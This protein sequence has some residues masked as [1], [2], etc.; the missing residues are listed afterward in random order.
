MT[1]NK[2]EAKLLPKQRDHIDYFYENDINMHPFH[3]ML[4]DT[5]EDF[6]NFKRVSFTLNPNISSMFYEEL[7]IIATSIDPV[8]NVPSFKRYVFFS[9]GCT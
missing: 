6:N 7:H 9:F 1:L 3:P 5:K 4:H 8:S 2:T